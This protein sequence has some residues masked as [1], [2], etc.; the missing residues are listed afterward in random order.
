MSKSIR[1]WLNGA[2]TAMAIW[3]D[4]GARMRKRFLERSDAEALYGDWKKVGQ[5]IQTATERYEQE[6]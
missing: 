2:S 5:D 1:N 4:I 6:K 3:P